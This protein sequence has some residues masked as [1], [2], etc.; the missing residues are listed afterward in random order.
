MQRQ[1][2][3]PSQPADSLERAMVSIDSGLLP[4]PLAT[5]HRRSLPSTWRRARAALL[6]YML[7]HVHRRPSLELSVRHA[8]PTTERV[9]LVDTRQIITYCS[10]G[11]S[12]VQKHC[13]AHFLLTS[14][15]PFFKPLDVYFLTQLMRSLQD[16]VYGGPFPF[17]G[18]VHG[19]SQSFSDNL[20]KSSLLHMQ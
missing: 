10:D 15:R 12:I 3:H 11:S 2:H 1:Y 18:N 4:L 5:V 9:P 19:A 14:S 17:H 7:R 6:H 8:P 13:P 20:G 16:E